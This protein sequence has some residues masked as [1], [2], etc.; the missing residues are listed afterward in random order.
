MPHLEVKLSANHCYCCGEIKASR[1]LWGQLPAQLS[2]RSCFSER[3][4]CVHPK[5]PLFP[6]RLW[7]S[8]LSPQELWLIILSGEAACLNKMS[9][10]TSPIESPWERKHVVIP[11]AHLAHTHAF[12]MKRCIVSA[13]VPHF[14]IGGTATKR[15]RCWQKWKGQ[16]ALGIKGIMATLRD[17][18]MSLHGGITEDRD[19]DVGTLIGLPWGSL[20]FSFSSYWKYTLT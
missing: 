11:S 10:H 4:L 3:P 17:Q 9:S 13:S 14:L 20:C 12:L 16:L 7:V 1:S 19:G 8:A 18:S 6:P 15:K 2:W 5:I